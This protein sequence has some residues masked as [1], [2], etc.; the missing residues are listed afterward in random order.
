MSF[1]IKKKQTVCIEYNCRNNL[2]VRE[3]SNIYLT[4]LKIQ[5]IT[6]I[7]C[8]WSHAIPCTDDTHTSNFSCI[9]ASDIS[10]NVLYNACRAVECI[11][12][13]PI[14]VPSFLR[15]LPSN[16]I[17]NWYSSSLALFLGS[18]REIVWPF[19]C[20]DRIVLYPCSI[21]LSSK[22]IMVDRKANR[23]KRNK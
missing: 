4:Y 15:C 8:L 18:C 20:A 14:Y 19:H 16:G 9:F 13:Y 22:T 7:V 21:A 2:D 11:R 3:I 5:H 6:G 12:S 23:V 10:P 17:G 1:P